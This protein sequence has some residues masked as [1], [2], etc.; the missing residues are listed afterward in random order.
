MT[1]TEDQPKC[2]KE[3][4]YKDRWEATESSSRAS[5]LKLQQWGGSIIIKPNTVV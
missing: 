1:T 3:K 5:F 2:W 4:G